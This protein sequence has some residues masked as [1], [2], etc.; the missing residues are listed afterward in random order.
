MENKT[1]NGDQKIK[2]TQIIN[3]GMQVMHEIDTLQ[4]G[5]T[6]TVKAIAEELE[7]KPAVL[8]KAIRMAHKASFGQEQQ[9][10][11]LLETIL[12]TVGKTL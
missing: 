3:E 4:G 10:H 12:T 11:E 2:L 6:D 1:F 9:D 5:L 7:I 8:K